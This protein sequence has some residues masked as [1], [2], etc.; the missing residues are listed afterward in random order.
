MTARCCAGALN[1][2]DEGISGQRTVLVENGILRTYM[3]DRVSAKIMGVEPTGNGRRQSFRHPPCQECE[4][5]T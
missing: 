3:H 2:D 5:L 1:H 4:R